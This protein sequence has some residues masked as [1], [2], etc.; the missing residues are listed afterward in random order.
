M[1][2]GPI[3]R[4]AWPKKL[5]ARRVSLDASPR[6][7]GY[8][9]RRDLAVHYGPSALLYVSLTGEL[10]TSDARARAFD[11]ALTWLA[12]VTIAEG[13]SHAA[14]LA[15]LVRSSN[16]AVLGTGAIALSEQVRDLLDRHEPV[17][18]WLADPTASFPSAF[19]DDGAAEDVASLV[20]QIEVD[21]PIAAHRPTLDACLLGLLYELG[22]TERDHIEAAIVW[23]RLPCVWAEALAVK[24]ADFAGYPMDL[25][26]FD[27][28]GADD[29]E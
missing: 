29:I 5:T 7:S 15:R 24:P 22:L 20:S 1:T 19:V 6:L 3:E 11:I 17:L 8:D 16:A 12:P 27:Y 28:E 9:V 21:L 18:R 26:H 13:P 14:A 4:F 2:D 10:F 23:A 25:P